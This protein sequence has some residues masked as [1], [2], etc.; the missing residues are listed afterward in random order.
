MNLLQAPTLLVG[1]LYIGTCATLR[2][3]WLALTLR[4][5]WEHLPDTKSSFFWFGSFALIAGTVRWSLLDLEPLPSVA[6]H[7][8]QAKL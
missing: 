2:H 5:D 4:P 8:G 3:A 1:Y 7:V 6:G